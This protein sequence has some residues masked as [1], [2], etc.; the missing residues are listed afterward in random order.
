MAWSLWGLN[1]SQ[2]PLPWEVG[3]AARLPGLPQL[4]A[5]A[6]IPRHEP[7]GSEPAA[8]PAGPRASDPRVPR[9]GGALVF[10]FTL[11]PTEVEVRSNSAT[12]H[13][14]Q[15]PLMHGQQPTSVV[16]NHDLNRQHQAP[17]TTLAIWQK[18]SSELNSKIT[19]DWPA[20]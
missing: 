11:H 3:P 2:P 7:D 18:G 16:L 19:W 6:A 4:E 13:F 14:R 15:V 12:G 20:I 10:F 9:G 5:R 17:R 8:S 1:S